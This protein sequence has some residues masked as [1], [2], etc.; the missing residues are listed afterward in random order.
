MSL[1]KL[2]H[3]CHKSNIP[4]GNCRGCNKYHQTLTE[5]YKSDEEPEVKLNEEQVISFDYQVRQT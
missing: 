1:L 4:C 3:S 5:L 2:A